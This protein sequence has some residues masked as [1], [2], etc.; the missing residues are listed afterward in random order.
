M[1][2]Q[3]K[4]IISTEA[5]I[6]MLLP[7]ICLCNSVH[8]LSIAAVKVVSYAPFKP[9]NQKGIYNSCA[10]PSIL[11]DIRF[12]MLQLFEASLDDGFLNPQSP[13]L[14]IA[15][16][17]IST[18]TFRVAGRIRSSLVCWRWNSIVARATMCSVFQIVACTMSFPVA[19][20]T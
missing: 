10:P 18:S 6:L 13:N 15:S 9:N 4:C 11:T 7:N 5:E 8:G 2:P 17:T 1:Q 3:G 12:N 20:C 19:Y 16:G 14:L